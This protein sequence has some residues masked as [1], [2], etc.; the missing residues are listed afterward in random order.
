M[1]HEVERQDLISS[2][3]KTSA[4]ALIASVM[5]RPAPRFPAYASIKPG[6]K[7]VVSS[8]CTHEM[9]HCMDP[10]DAKPTSRSKSHIQSG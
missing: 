6:G 10:G 5:P 8:Y 2:L 7:N 9:L 4:V 3:L 1:E